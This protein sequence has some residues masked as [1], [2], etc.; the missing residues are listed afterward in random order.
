MKERVTL[1]NLIVSNTHDPEPDGYERIGYDDA[2]EGGKYNDLIRK[3]CMEMKKPWKEWSWMNVGKNDEGA[4]GG[5]GYNCVVK[6]QNTK[7]SLAVMKL[8]KET[9]MPTGSVATTSVPTTISGTVEPT[10]T[11]PETTP[12]KVNRYG[13][14]SIEYKLGALGDASCPIGYAHLKTLADCKEAADSI[15][16]DLFSS[17]FPFPPASKGELTFPKGCFFLGVANRFL[18][19]DH[20]A[21]SG[22]KRLRTLCGRMTTTTAPETTPIKVYKN[23]RIFKYKLGAPGNASCAIGYA[24]LKTL[25]DCKEAADYLGPGLFS[26]NL[27]KRPEL[28]LIFPKGCFYAGLL[29]SGVLYNDQDAGSR[30]KKCLYCMTLCGRMARTEAATTATTTALPATTEASPVSLI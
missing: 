11:A 8:K 16:P 14:I 3:L 25:A 24:H 22:D 7:L 13:R 30:H 15:G 9:T 4:V 19:N 1:S 17:D 5:P 10:T 26:S 21:G 2:K 12:I 6:K 18:Y 29:H 23:D 28:K 20:D 27:Q